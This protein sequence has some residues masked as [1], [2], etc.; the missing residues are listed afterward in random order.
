MSKIHTK[1]KVRES[2]TGKTWCAKG[3]N[4]F[5]VK[6][7]MNKENVEVLL[8]FEKRLDLGRQKYL[9]YDSSS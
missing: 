5:S 8:G 3:Q 1:D 6:L 4:H 9:V 2:A 7:H